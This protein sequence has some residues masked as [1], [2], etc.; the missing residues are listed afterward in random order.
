[1]RVLR[2][3]HLPVPA[4]DVD[5]DRFREILDRCQ[6]VHVVWASS[7][8]RLTGVAVGRVGQFVAHLPGGPTA[9]CDIGRPVADVGSVGRAGA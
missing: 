9:P 6:V 8:S 1:M 7:S 5:K 4:V 3:L 2:F